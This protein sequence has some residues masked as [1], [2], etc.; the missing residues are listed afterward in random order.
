MVLVVAAAVDDG[1]AIVVLGKVVP[2]VVAGV[3][4]AVTGFAA[5]LGRVIGASV[6]E[7]KKQL[8]LQ[9]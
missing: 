5:C 1:V 8:L 4:A 9:S 6:A 2:A 7:S 3:T